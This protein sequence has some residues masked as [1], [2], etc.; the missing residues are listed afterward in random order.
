MKIDFEQFL[1]N[2]WQEEVTCTENDCL[3][4]DMPEAFNKWMC[5]LD[6]EDF[7]KYGNEFAKY[8]N[9]ELIDKIIDKKAI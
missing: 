4:D 8:V 9:S 5:E 6:I 3:D 2:K 7:I 1:T